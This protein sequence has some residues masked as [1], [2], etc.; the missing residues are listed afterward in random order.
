M[1]S[2]APVSSNDR[3][4]PGDPRNPGS[5][6]PSRANRVN[7]R[8]AA[9]A[10]SSSSAAASATVATTAAAAVTQAAASVPVAAAAATEAAA[11]AVP[12]VA[13]AVVSIA[14]AVVVVAKA[15]A[16]QAVAAAA[17]V[18]RVSAAPVVVAAAA[19]LAGLPEGRVTS[20]VAL[21]PAQHLSGVVVPRSLECSVSSSG[22]QSQFCSTRDVLGS[23][24]S[25]LAPELISEQF[26]ISELGM[27]DAAVPMA[28]KALAA[29]R[30]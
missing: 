26:C 4:R 9:R 2:L 13:A 19:A 5:H 29:M 16:A 17:A 20:I 28:C 24:D 1:V 23:F 27:G 12:A 21:C 8:P 7:R 3:R 18:A 30:R 15:F 10:S 6:N 25:S 22:R 14:E 11:A